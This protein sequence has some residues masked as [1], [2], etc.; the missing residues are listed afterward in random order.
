MLRDTRNQRKLPPIDSSLRIGAISVSPD[1]HCAAVRFGDSGALSHPALYSNDGEQPRLLI[2]DETA[3]GDWL[4]IVSTAAARVLRA[5]LPPVVVDGQTFERPTILPLPN[6]LAGLGN[7]TARLGRIAE[8]GEGLLPARGQPR[9]G[10][11]TDTEACLLFNYL[12]GNITSAMADLDALDQKTTDFDQ[13]LSILSMRAMLR[14]A[15][16]DPDQA[17]QIIAYL[18]SNTGTS[19][20]RVEETPQGQVIEKTAVPAQAWAQFLSTRA[21]E[22][23]AQGDAPASPENVDPLDPLAGAAQRRLLELP[24]FP[25]E[26]GGAGGPFAPL[27]APD[28]DPPARP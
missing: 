17:R 22:A 13:R 3:R 24:E 11:S 18:I 7:V 14:W 21:A 8:L 5:S 25:F 10:C 2:P 6:E 15:Q 12:R 20:L 4:K 28:L 1:G 26:P 9:E 27:P 19:T 23:K 16:G